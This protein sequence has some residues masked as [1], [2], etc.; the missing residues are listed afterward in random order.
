VVTLTLKRTVSY[1]D[2]SNPGHIFRVLLHEGLLYYG[3]ICTIT[4]TFT[5]MIVSTTQSIRNVTGQLELCI[6]VAMM[7]RITLHLKGYHDRRDG[8]IHSTPIHNRLFDRRY[9]TMPDTSIIAFAPG[10]TVHVQS[11]REPHSAFLQGRREYPPAGLGNEESFMM[12]TLSVTTTL[13]TEQPT[14]LGYM[15]HSLAN[16]PPPEFEQLGIDGGVRLPVIPTDS[17]KK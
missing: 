17:D 1:L 3:V 11:P 14:T 15:G 7:S 13:P 2:S 4:L 6:T 8:V 5:I 9:S 10:R 16:E 12:D